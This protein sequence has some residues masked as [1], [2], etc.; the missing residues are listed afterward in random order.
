MKLLYKSN[1][2]KLILQ[3]AK[4]AGREEVITR[5]DH[6]VYRHLERKLIEHVRAMIG[7]HPSGKRTLMK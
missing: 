6:T 1:I 2:R 3:E 4:E 7:S 5:V